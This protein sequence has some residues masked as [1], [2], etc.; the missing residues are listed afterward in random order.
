MEEPCC[1]DFKCH[2]IVFNTR[3]DFQFGDGD[4][5]DSMSF[6]G[7]NR[8]VTLPAYG[9][10]PEICGFV[11]AHSAETGIVFLELKSF[12]EALYPKSRRL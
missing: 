8:R 3:M 6:P 7:A 2:K 10:C 5:G 12:K 1:T 11:P 4:D 9:K